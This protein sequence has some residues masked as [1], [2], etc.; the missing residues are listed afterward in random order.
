[1]GRTN[2]LAKPGRTLNAVLFDEVTAHW[3]S[4]GADVF[5]LITLISEALLLSVAAQTGFLGG[6]RVLVN[7]ASIFER[8]RELLEY[9]VIS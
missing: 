7:N 5:V 3:S 4:G 6:P 9:L 1:M 2:V 8:D